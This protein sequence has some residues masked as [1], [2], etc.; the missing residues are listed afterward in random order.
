MC[1]PQS[2]DMWTSR[3]HHC[4]AVV[5]SDI[6]RGRSEMTPEEFYGACML[7][8]MAHIPKRKAVTLFP[9]LSWRC[10]TL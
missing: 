7:C 4:T 9:L 5:E 2:G 10:W 3:G 6:I 8:C 1:R